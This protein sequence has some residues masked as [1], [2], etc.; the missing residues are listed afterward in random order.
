MALYLIKLSFNLW[1]Y[2]GAT[3]ELLVELVLIVFSSFKL[4][5]RLVFFICSVIEISRSE[6]IFSY[7][8]YQ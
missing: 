8:F 4:E 3:F 6:G 7:W 1:Y 5:Q 2:V